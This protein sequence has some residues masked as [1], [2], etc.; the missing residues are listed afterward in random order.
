[1]IYFN[2]FVDSEYKG[3]TMDQVT[4]SIMLVSRHNQ[5]YKSIEL[6]G[7]LQDTARPSYEFQANQRVGTC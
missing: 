1:M 4:G 5:L 3:E 2:K 7:W 6:V